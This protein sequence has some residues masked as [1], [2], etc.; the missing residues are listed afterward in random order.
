MIKELT[1]ENM[2]KEERRNMENHPKKKISANFG[3]KENVIMGE[4]VN[5]HTCVGVVVK[6]IIMYQEIAQKSGK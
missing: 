3:Y 6:W 2:E 4:D 5:G 1:R